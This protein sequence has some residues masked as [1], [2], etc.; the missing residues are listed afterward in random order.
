MS[1]LT[2]NPRFHAMIAAASLNSKSAATPEEIE[3]NVEAEED[4]LIEPLANLDQQSDEEDSE[5]AMPGIETTSI[6]MMD[7][8][9]SSIRDA[10]KGVSEKTAAEY[11]R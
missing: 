4:A 8:L 3:L 5:D 2:N 11:Q 1:R 6:S 9:R 10:S 7:R